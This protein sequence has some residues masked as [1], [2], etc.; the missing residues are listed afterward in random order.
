[1][2]DDRGRRRWPR[3][4]RSEPM[5]ET[6]AATATKA[7]PAGE[8]GPGDRCRLP[9]VVRCRSVRQGQRLPAHDQHDDD[10][11]ERGPPGPN[12]A[13]SAGSETFVCSVGDLGLEDAD[14]QPAEEGERERPEAAD[15]RRG[16]P[17]DDQQREVHDLSPVTLTM[18]IAATT[19][20]IGAERPVPVATTSGEMPRTAVARRSSATRRRREAEAGPA[21]HGREQHRAGG[22]D[23]EQDQAVGA[24][25]DVGPEV[26]GVDRED[27][28]R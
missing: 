24:D 25:D 19:A 7:T 9:A 14:Q 26:D 11:D 21:V 13:A 1:M 2:A 6:N 8:R 22:G 4:G 18:R 20:R 27:L 5:I 16:Q 10:H 12:P 3:R 17:G 15:Q 23:A 28:A